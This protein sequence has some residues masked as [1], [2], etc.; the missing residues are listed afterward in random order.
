MWVTNSACIANEVAKRK[1]GGSNNEEDDIAAIMRGLKGQ[2][3]AE[4]MLGALGEGLVC[5]EETNNEL[6][7][8][9]TE[10]EEEC[11]D[12]VNGRKL[13]AHKVRGAR[14]VELKY[15]EDKG[16]GELAPIKTCWG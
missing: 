13:E 3:R 10:F 15:F 2:L 6:Q 8:E 1:R 7:E 16:V 12:D 14:K 9:S 11:W 4:G 5:C